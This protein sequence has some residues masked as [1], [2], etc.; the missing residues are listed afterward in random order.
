MEFDFKLFVE[1]IH[2]KPQIGLYKCQGQK[3][4]IQA[5]DGFKQHDND[6]NGI[7]DEERLKNDKHSAL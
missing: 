3:Y 2:A 5:S 4:Q 1:R 6:E 7:N